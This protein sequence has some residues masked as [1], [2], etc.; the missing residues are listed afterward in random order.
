M[1]LNNTCALILLPNISYSLK[2]KLGK[3]NLDIPESIMM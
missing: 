3:V 2:K 1:Q